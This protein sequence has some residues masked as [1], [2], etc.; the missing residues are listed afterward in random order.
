MTRNRHLERATCSVGCF[1]TYRETQDEHRS[2]ICLYRIVVRFFDKRRRISTQTRCQVYTVASER[3]DRRSYF[4]FAPGEKDELENGPHYCCTK[5]QI[6]NGC[7]DI[8]DE[9]SSPFI[10]EIAFR[11]G[12][13]E[14]GE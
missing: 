5:I 2:E 9:L 3:Y 13:I 11:G 1:C 8:S 14:P 4:P 10:V 12:K 7:D 6:T